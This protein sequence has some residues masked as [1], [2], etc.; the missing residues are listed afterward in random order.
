MQRVGGFRRKTR[1]KLK[2]NVRQKGKINIRKYFQKFKKGDKVVFKAEPAIQKGMYHPRFHG[3]VGVV[4]GKTGNCYDVKI[5]DGKKVKLFK[6]H[7]IHLKM[8]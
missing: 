2:K 6:V 5:K 8:V 1:N 4:T 3:K 7:P